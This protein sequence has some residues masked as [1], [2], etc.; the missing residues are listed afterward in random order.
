MVFQERIPAYV[1]GERRSI[2]VVAVTETSP[3]DF[4]AV[5]VKLRIDYQEYPTFTIRPLPG[6]ERT[7]TKNIAFEFVGYNPDNGDCEG[8]GLDKPERIID[9]RPKYQMRQEFT[10]T[11]G[12]LGVGWWAQHVVSGY[13]PTNP[14]KIAKGKQ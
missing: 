2:K 6:W 13:K 5:L 9:E 12:V 10:K 4:T 7:P 3:E 8:F 1:R 11:I 14:Y